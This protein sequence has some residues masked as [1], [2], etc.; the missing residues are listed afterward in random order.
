MSQSPNV[1]YRKR[2]SVKEIFPDSPEYDWSE[3]GANPSTVGE[4]AAEWFNMIKESFETFEHDKKSSIF[5]EYGHEY[6]DKTNRTIKDTNLLA[7]FSI[8]QIDGF[9]WMARTCIFVHTE[10]ESVGLRP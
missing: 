4:R 5:R 3:T 9:P 8:L 7:G 10:A 2:E 1:S 6:S